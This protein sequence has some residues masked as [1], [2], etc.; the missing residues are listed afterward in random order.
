MVSR[1]NEFEFDES[2]TD[3]MAPQWFTHRPALS[4]AIAILFLVLV[5][6]I[7]FREPLLGRKNF[8]IFDHATYYVPVH[9][10]NAQQRADGEIPLWNRYGFLG[11]PIQAENQLSGVYLPALIFNLVDDPGRAYTFYI[12]FHIL[13]AA[14]GTMYL[15]RVVGAGVYGQIV[16]ALIFTFG[17][18]FVGHLASTM[19]TTVA[20]APIILGLQL[21]SFQT[22]S[23]NT[24]IVAG[25]LLAIQASGAHPQGGIYQ[26]LLMIGAASMEARAPNRW[27]NLL[28]AA[29]LT[30][31]TGS[32]GGCLSFPQLYYCWEH[33][34]QSARGQGVAITWDQMADS[35]PPQYLLQLIVPD[36]LRLE[37]NEHRFYF[38]ILSLALICLGWGHRGRFMPH[39]RVIFIIG[40]VLSLGRFG[41]LYGLLSYLPLF[42]SMRSPMRICVL[43]T[44][45]AAVLAGIGLDRWLREGREIVRFRRVAASAYGLLAALLFVLA[46]LFWMNRTDPQ[47]RSAYQSVISANIQPGP[48]SSLVPSGSQARFEL[49]IRSVF[50]AG[51]LGT[52]CAVFWWYPFRNVWGRCCIGIGSVSLLAA[53]LLICNSTVEEF[54]SPDYY[55]KLPPAIAKLREDTGLWR[56]YRAFPFEGNRPDPAAF[57]FCMSSLFGFDALNADGVALPRQLEEYWWG[58]MSFKELSL[59]NIKYI[60]TREPVLEGSQA[61]M[62]REVLQDGE[63]HLYE[64]ADW[65]P[66]VQLREQFVVR[67]DSVRTFINSDAFVLTESVVIEQQPEF[68]KGTPIKDTGINDSVHVLHYSAQRVVIDADVSRNTILV[69]N[70]LYYP[71]WRAT[72]NGTAVKVLRANNIVRGVALGAGRHNVEFTYCPTSFYRGLYISGATCIIV[73]GFGGLWLY[74]RQTRRQAVVLRNGRAG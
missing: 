63:Y 44:L 10:A 1:E 66:R 39:F 57:P 20:W 14:I 17:G 37:I 16:A 6:V 15:T 46:C 55:S 29:K 47:L 54:A 58:R 11:Y 18:S 49:A 71:G 38:G 19:L 35:L 3:S 51:V 30:L 41:V 53:D 4:T 73:L 43:V 62:S 40:L 52:V 27:T 32:V 48:R 34:A 59:Y 5:T 33:I 65:Q 24:A 45:A 22:R 26:I 7:F 31:V 2:P 56:A 68:L 25:I 13:L 50:A 60:L 74:R 36:L 23:F 67:D 69:L 64:T 8:F 61:L 28:V 21:R 9:V 70:D 42:R 12:L 72:S